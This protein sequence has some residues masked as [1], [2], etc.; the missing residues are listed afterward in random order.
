LEA[1]GEEMRVYCS[2]STLII[3]HNRST[4]EEYGIRTSICLIPDREMAWYACWIS[5]WYENSNLLPSKS[6]P[7]SFSTK[8]E[9]PTIHRDVP[10]EIEVIDHEDEGCNRDETSFSEASYLNVG[11][12]CVWPSSTYHGY[13]EYPGDLWILGNNA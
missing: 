1:L 9:K 11:F 8:G 5:H 7:T 2:P 13:N 3:I 6:S 4:F 12:E 10:K